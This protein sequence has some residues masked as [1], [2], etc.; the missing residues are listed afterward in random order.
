M[1]TLDI[2]NL[3]MGESRPGPS[4]SEREIGC[5]TV[6]LADDYDG[7]VSNL[8]QPRRQIISED[9]LQI[10]PERKGT[11]QATATVSWNGPQEKSILLDETNETADDGGQ[12][13]LCHLLTFLT[14]RHVATAEYCERFSPHG[15][16]D[17]AVAQIE[18][19]RATALAWQNRA[20]LVPKK[21]HLAL[22][23]YNEAMNTSLLQSRAAL[24]CTALNIILDQHH[25]DQQCHRNQQKV[26]KRTKKK[27][28]NA[29]S[30]ILANTTELQ[31]DQTKQ[32]KRM[33]HRQ[34]DDGPTLS[35]TLSDKLI[36]LLQSLEIIDTPPTLDQK[37]RVRY[38]N[39]VRNV[40]THTG[41]IP[42][43]K[44]L[45][46]QSGNYTANIVAAVIPTIIR[47]VIGNHLGF[48]PG[49][50]G[51]YCV[52]KGDV[53]DFFQNGVFRGQ[54]LDFFQNG[55]FRDMRFV[56]ICEYLLE[57]NAELY[58]RLS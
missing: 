24:Y 4:R 58:Q 46:E 57:K 37:T 32:Y 47:I 21:L 41:R 12:W 7:K 23:L 16:G 29:I 48:R 35:F 19:L 26:N 28:R 6:R 55:V 27:L 10:L 50:T 31:P 9:G 13:D 5:L 43:L 45:D 15:H 40:L 11:W 38:V 22:L 20:N 44:G 52:I 39:K 1:K 54:R 56:E 14:G 53:I 51:S 30:G 2:F 18:T 17:Y 33:L 34:I 42:N 36:S 8:S 25:R 3:Y 49:S